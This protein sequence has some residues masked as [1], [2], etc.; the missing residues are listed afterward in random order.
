M[1]SRGERRVYK[2]LFK[3]HHPIWGSWGRAVLQPMAA[4]GR[5]WLGPVP[6]L[7]LTSGQ[8]AWHQQELIIKWRKKRRRKVCLVS[9][10]CLMVLS[11]VQDF[12]KA[13]GTFR[14]LAGCATLCLI[15]KM[16]GIQHYK[17][18]GI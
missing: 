15:W 14:D 9:F 11:L 6:W 5:W 8:H 17:C 1:L 3:A 10:N 18:L 2:L 4:E 16:S 12:P 7:C 13:G